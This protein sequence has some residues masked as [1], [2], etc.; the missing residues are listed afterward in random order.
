MNDHKN[1]SHTKVKIYSKQEQKKMSNF[2]LSP[3]LF[4]LELFLTCFFSCQNGA[5]KSETWEKKERKKGEYKIAAFLYSFL[6]ERKMKGKG[7]KGKVMFFCC[8]F[9]VSVEGKGK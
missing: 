3:K 6:L 4:K 5:I 2:F 7:K 8:Y 1:S 9:L